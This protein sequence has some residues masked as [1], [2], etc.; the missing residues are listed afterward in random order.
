VELRRRLPIPQK[1]VCPTADFFISSRLSFAFIHVINTAQNHFPAG[2][3]EKYISNGGDF[4]TLYAKST[5]AH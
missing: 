2:F 4:H 3:G 1:T 5:K